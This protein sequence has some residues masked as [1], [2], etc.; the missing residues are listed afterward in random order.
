MLDILAAGSAAA[1]PPAW[2]SLLPVVGMVA[3]FWFLIIRPQMRQQKAHREKIAGVSKGDQVVTSGG[4]VGKV[5]RVDDNYADVEIAPGVKVKVVKS[6][7]GDII[8]AGG[9][10]AN[11]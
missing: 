8:P 2:T 11:D 9:M 1:G 5:L 10:P 7:I 3:I 6:T 4:I